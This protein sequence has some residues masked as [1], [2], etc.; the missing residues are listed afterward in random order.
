MVNMLRDEEEFKSSKFNLKYKL[1]NN[2][3]LTNH[4]VDI[5]KYPYAIL[6]YLQDI[7]KIKLFIVFKEHEV[8]Q[9]KDNIRLFTMLKHAEHIEEH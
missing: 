7:Q 6:V 9:K 5:L 8:L 3:V 4:V 2:D 1:K